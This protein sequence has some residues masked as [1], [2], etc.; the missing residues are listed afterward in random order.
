MPCQL[1]SECCMKVMKV[2]TIKASTHA[3]TIF[4]RHRQN[5]SVRQ[6]MDHNEGMPNLFYVVRLNRSWCDCGKF[7][8]FRIPCSH[9]IAACAHTRQDA[10]NHLFD[11]YKAITVMNVYNESFSVLA[12]EE[13]WPPYEGDIVCNTTMRCEERKKDG[14]ITRVLEQKWIQLIKW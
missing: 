10:Y 11:V 3:V 9:V 4:D 2:E 14:Q 12:M 13:Y 7:Q 1:F 5:F 8:V 6:T